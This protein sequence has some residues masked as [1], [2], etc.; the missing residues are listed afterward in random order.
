MNDPYKTLGVQPNASESEIKSAYKTLVKKYHP[1]RYTDSDMAEL[2]NEK[3]TEIN[4]AYDRIMEDRRQGIYYDSSPSGRNMSGTYNSS[5]YTRSGS[6]SSSGGSGFSYGRTGTYD[7]NFNYNYQ[8]RN[9]SFDAYRVRQLA[10]QGDI[11]GADNIL[12]AVPERSRN[13]EWNY[14]KGMVSYRRG[15]FNE[16]YHYTAKATQMDPANQEYSAAFQQM[17]RQRSGYMTGN[18]FTS[19]AP[20]VRGTDPCDI[21]SGLC[22]ADCCCEMMGGDLIPCC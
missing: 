12:M 8:Q 10:D 9:T 7:Q 16:A 11:N 4:A 14:L 13:A 20:S 21:M 1:D 17:N 19:N 5:N 18:A 22:A 2:A 15:W 6:S 3:M